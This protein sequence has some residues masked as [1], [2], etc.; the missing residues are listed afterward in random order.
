M[1]IMEIFIKNLLRASLVGSI[2]IILIMVFRK[3]LF[4]KYTSSFNYYIWLVVIFKMIMPFKISINIPE[5]IYNSFHSQP[6]S[7]KTI[8]NDS[9]SINQSIE[10]K[11]N[12]NNLYVDNNTINYFTIIFYI[13][14]TISILFLIYHIISYLNYNSKIKNLI[15]DIPNNEIKNMYSMLLFE[16]NIKKKISLK[17]CKEISTPFGIGIFNAHILIPDVSYDIQELEY[18]LRHELM[19]YKRFDMVYK[20]LL[21]ITVT[22][23][24]FNPLVYIMYKKINNDCEFSC[25]E[26]VLKNSSIEE[27]K[28]YALTLINSLRLN[29]NNVM[30]QNLIMGFN[31]KNILKK[32]L[33][34]MLNLKARKKG[35]FVGIL[36]VVVSII[37]LIRINAIVKNGS[38]ITP[39]TPSLQPNQVIENHFKY[40]NADNKEGLFTTVTDWQKAPNV[41]WGFNKHKY[42]YIEINS[43]SEDVRP[44][45][46]EGYIK[47]GRGEINGTT[48]E[49]LKVYT[50]NYTIKYKF[51]LTGLLGE[52]I[53]TS[54]F[55]IRKDNN[56]PWLID[57]MGEG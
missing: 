54:Y 31:S 10:T 20:I 44:S 1:V 27:R 46:K 4:K 19:H 6:N 49:N 34:S 11:N 9:F 12:I 37:S 23:H 14:L 33:E 41:D 35:L 7:I 39:N 57:D 42:K 2:C 43:I 26:A 15:Y 22:L 38:L 47:Y 3:N 48:E 25:D 16:M 5:K 30:K 45:Q 50:V 52:K 13:W 21:L 18:I 17:F 53:S 36:V 8:V 29:N 56:S 55:L 51:D 32:R 40:I 28:L 24:W